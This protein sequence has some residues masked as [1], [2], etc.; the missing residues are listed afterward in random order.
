MP[1]LNFRL[2]R[3]DADAAAE[4]CAVS[5][6][7]DARL[8][9]RRHAVGERQVTAEAFFQGPYTTALAPEEILVEVRLPAPPPGAG[10]AFEEV[11]R[12][13]G[14]SRWWGWQRC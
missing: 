1:L 13:R 3:P 9:A 6:A 10:W 11:A 8:V 5:L 4:L 12:R 7:L 2:A 14:T